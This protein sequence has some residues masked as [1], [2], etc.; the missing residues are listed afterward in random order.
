MA[1]GALVS[2]E[3]AAGAISIGLV[4]GI[5]FGVAT[6]S[7]NRLVRM[8]AGVYITVIRGTPLLLQIFFLFLGGPQLFRLI[9]GHS[10]SPDPLVTGILALGL[11][12]GAYTAEIIRAGIQSIDRGQTEGALSLGL[13]KMQ[14]MRYVILPQALRRM[15]PP[16]GNEL[17][18]MLKDSSLISAIGVYDLMFTAKLLGAKYYTY[19]P[20]L[21]GAAVIYLI[22]TMMIQRTMKYLERR[23]PVR[24]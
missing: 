4:L 7:S 12:S 9:T 1:K 13:K 10:I 22:M 8:A 21:M 23:W 14:V 18:V 19:V 15:V 20:F 5:I 2:L 6:L 17:I 3:V 16:L 24:V 11:N